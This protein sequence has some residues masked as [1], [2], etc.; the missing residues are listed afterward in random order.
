MK[1]VIPTYGIE[2][3]KSYKN[4]G[5]L[6]S[7]FGYYLS[8]HEHLLRPHRHDFYHL[9][10]FTAGAG[11]QQ[12]DFNSFEIK[13]GLIYFMIPGQVHHWRFDAEPEGYI[14][15]FS[16]SYFS[17][18][19]L[20]ADYLSRFA[21]FHA[22]ASRQ[23]MELPE[24]M[25]QK[26]SAILE[27]ILAAGGPETPVDDDLVKVLLLRLFMEISLG[28]PAAQDR[29]RLGYNHTLIG[30]FK[31]LIEQNYK[32]LKLPK[33]YAALLYITPNHLNA[34]CN[35]FLGTS[36]GA[37]IRQ[38]VLLEAKRLLVVPDLRISEI[39]NELEFA[40]QSYFI[41]FFKKYEGQTPDKF[42]K[43]NIA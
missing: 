9:V 5:I 21:F 8:Q 22:D 1:S 39:A 20:H 12:L 25:Q 11:R 32:Q 27:E 42:R 24:E 37:L 13:P 36:A 4:K 43:T 15:N 14:I 3:L 23:V 33:Q 16:S 34:V 38:R 29:E 30:N 19:L 35:D 10:F 31:E 26:A 7:R 40:D 6:V 17:A 28:L 2:T 18:F 41:K